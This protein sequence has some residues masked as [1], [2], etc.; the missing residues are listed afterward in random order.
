MRTVFRLVDSG[1][2]DC[3][4]VE[5]WVAHAA[6][7]TTVRRIPSTGDPEDPDDVDTLEITA[8]LDS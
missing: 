4:D 1:G 7:I 3:L 2:I 6:T 8:V 5:P